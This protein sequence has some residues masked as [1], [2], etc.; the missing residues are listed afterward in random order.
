MVS[1]RIARRVAAAGLA[2][3]C[4]TT[5]LVVTGTPAQATPAG[6]VVV[7]AISTFSSVGFKTIAAVCPRGKSVLGGG[8]SAITTEGS[9]YRLLISQAYPDGAGNQFVAAAFE[10]AAGTSDTWRIA[11]YAICANPLR[12]LEYVATP[13]HTNISGTWAVCSS[14]KRLVGMGGQV[15]GGNG[16]VA[17][18][19]IFPGGSPATRA[20]TWVTEDPSGFAGDYQVRASAVCADPVDG[21]EYVVK[22]VSNT[23]GVATWVD[24]PAGKHVLSSGARLAN[25]SV[26]VWHGEAKFSTIGPNLSATFSALV[27][28]QY[29]DSGQTFTA[30]AIAMCA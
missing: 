6:L 12:G 7:T 3:V 24:C 17:L 26:P 8:A 28:A 14:G 15:L 9:G 23:P 21:L 11:A 30:Q 10:E 4:G 27:A 5:V 18:A 19:G 2:I 22:S 1:V 25:G 20:E 16:E 13:F 29:G